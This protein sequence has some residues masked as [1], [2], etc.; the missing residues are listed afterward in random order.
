MCNHIVK[1]NVIFGSEILVTSHKRVYMNLMFHKGLA[2]QGSS[3]CKRRACLNF[4]AF[5]LHDI[6]MMNPEG[7]WV[8]QKMSYPFI[9]GCTRG[10]IYFNALYLESEQYFFVS[11]TKLS[12]RCFCYFT[13]TMFVFLQRTQTYGVSIQRSINLGKTLLQITLE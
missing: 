5:A 4:Q 3:Y 8:G 12:D 1:L 13:A 9:T 11:I 7:C 2:R 10:S 6:K